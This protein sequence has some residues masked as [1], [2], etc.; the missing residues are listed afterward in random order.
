MATDGQFQ[1]LKTDI[2]EG[3]K[4]INERIDNLVTRNELNAELKRIDEKH[5]QHASDTRREFANRDRIN[6]E[7]DAVLDARLDQ[8]TSTTKWAVG[9]AAT[10]AAIIISVINIFV[11]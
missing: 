9:I 1:E 3:F 10:L 8:F 11:P 2:R 4:A 6:L 5:E 7:R